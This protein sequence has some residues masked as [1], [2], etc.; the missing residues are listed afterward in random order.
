MTPAVRIGCGPIAA[1]AGGLYF[2]A[3]NGS[4]QTASSANFCAAPS[5]VALTIS[6]GN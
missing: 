3:A 5:V 6:E 2:A 1:I 4:E